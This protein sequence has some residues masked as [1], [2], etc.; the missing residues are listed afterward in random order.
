MNDLV[1]L[2]GRLA[3]VLPEVYRRDIGRDP[4]SLEIMEVLRD[5]SVLGFCTELMANS[6]EVVLPL[7]SQLEGV[8]RGDL[9][10]LENR[11]LPDP[12]TLELVGDRLAL[13]VREEVVS[14]YR[15]SIENMTKGTNPKRTLGCPALYG[16]KFREVFR[17]VDRSFEAWVTHP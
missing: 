5:P 16:G 14:A 10:N 4:S 12:F 11:F 7:I 17:W 2:F 3:G 6:K 1:V 8:E 9:N 15:Q 13:R